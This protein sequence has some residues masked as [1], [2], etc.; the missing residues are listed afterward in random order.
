[1]VALSDIVLNKET[2]GQRLGVGIKR[3]QR[4]VT[5]HEWRSADAEV[6]VGSSRL[7]AETEEIVDAEAR[8]QRIRIDRSGGAGG[9]RGEAWAMA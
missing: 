1:V 9:R 2:R 5:T 4:S 8:G 6:N 3:L 7:V